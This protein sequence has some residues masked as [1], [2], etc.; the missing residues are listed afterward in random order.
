MPLSKLKIMI[1]AD[2]YVPGF[3]AGGPITSAFKMIQLLGSDVEFSVLTRNHDWH[4]PEPYV[5]PFD[6]WID[7]EG[8][9][10]KYLSND[11]PSNIWKHLRSESPDLVYLNG[12]YS[13]GFHALPLI[14]M[15]INPPAAKIIVAPRGMLNANAIQLKKG[16]KRL[17]LSMYR[18]LGIESKVLFHSTGETETESI[19][20][21]FKNA[22]VRVAANVPAELK[23]DVELEEGR[24]GLLSVAR[25]SKVKNPLAL[26]RL[27]DENPVF[28]T[29]FIGTTDEESYFDQC[30]RIIQRNDHIDWVG[31]VGPDAIGKYYRAAKYFVSMT[32]GENFG[33][34]IIEALAHGCPVIISDRTPWND[35]EDEGAGWV[36]PL[37]DE[38]RWRNTLDMAAT[39]DDE[40]YAKMSVNA[41]AYV[42]RKFDLIELKNQ[43][44]HLFSGEN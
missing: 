34:A 4:D 3:K 39:M 35:L 43:Y 44:L 29:K 28:E 24:K 42:K 18:L 37:D 15:L 19:R 25:I 5:L 22:K 33:H 27:I 41:V 17:L 13:P 23:A 8:A 2:W 11:S 10:V 6:V 1:V 7:G 40:T 31:G 36:I 16:K 21:V 26:L 14:R 32:T 38:S 9:R 20:R 12:L 30:D